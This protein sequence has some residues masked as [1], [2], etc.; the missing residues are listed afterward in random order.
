MPPTNLT[1]GAD[2]APANNNN[3]N[4]EVLELYRGE[5]EDL[6]R[7]LQESQEARHREEEAQR[8]IAEL[9]RQLSEARLESTS[10]KE[11]TQ[12]TS[13]VAAKDAEAVTNAIKYLDAVI[14]RVS[15]KSK[16]KSRTQTTRTRKGFNDNDDAK[17]AS[18]T[19]DDVESTPLRTNKQVV[20]LEFCPT[21]PRQISTPT[22]HQLS[23]DNDDDS[24]SWQ[25]AGAMK[26]LADD[27][28]SVATSSLA[29]ADGAPPSVRFG[30]RSVLSSMYGTASGCA[31]SASASASSWRPTGAM[32]ALV[33]GMPDDSTVNTWLTAGE[34]DFE[35]MQTCVS[36]LTNLTGG[37]SRGTPTGGSNASK[38]T[39]TTTKDDTAVV[40]SQLYHIQRLL[41]T[42]LK[43]KENASKNDTSTIGFEEK[44]RHEPSVEEMSS[45][46]KNIANLWENQLDGEK[47]TG[48]N[49]DRDANMKEKAPTT[50]TT[51]DAK[52]VIA[53][54]A[55]LF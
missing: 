49:S 9:R 43:D 32:A 39:T 10:A 8:E 29:G 37:K 21:L 3:N 24:G 4:E 41:L 12:L 51:E 44:D 45:R 25:P 36:A 13:T 47:C 18:N 5:I 33:A 48:A 17:E 38:T 55:G 27:M 50:L 1:S 53:S 54:L 19:S 28:S 26:R 14:Q 11:V 35:D 22:L 7:Q 42:V 6:R 40:V 46:A 52:E 34:D 16:S 30:P 15:S 2:G 31:S 23:T 20:E